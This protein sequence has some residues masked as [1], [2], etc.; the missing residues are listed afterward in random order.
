MS[1]DT[2]LIT[3]TQTVTLRL[4]GASRTMGELF[5]LCGILCVSRTAIF[6]FRCKGG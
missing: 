5:H 2:V 4:H 6:Y 3:S 1:N